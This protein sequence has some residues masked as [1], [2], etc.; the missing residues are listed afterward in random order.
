MEKAKNMYQFK[1]LSNYVIRK[2]YSF[3]H[4]LLLVFF[5]SSWDKKGESEVT[6]IHYGLLLYR[7]HEYNDYTVCIMLLNIVAKW[8]GL[9]LHI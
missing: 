6:L 4:L 2:L 1:V 8:S 7:Y 3:Y 5:G 9:L